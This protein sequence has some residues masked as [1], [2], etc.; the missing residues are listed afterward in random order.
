M[1]N[2]TDAQITYQVTED[3]YIN[4]QRL[5]R[6]RSSRWAHFGRWIMVLIGLAFAGLSLFTKLW[7]GVVV[8]LVYATMPWWMHRLISE[9]L[10]RRQY[11]KYPAIHQPQTLGVNDNGVVCSSIAGESRLTWN[12]ITRW[13]QDD[14]YLLLYVQPRLYFIIPKRADNAGTVIGRLQQLL[15]QHLGPAR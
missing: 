11:R 9:P 10:A 5:H 7:W 2:M 14:N 3:D 6:Q 1:S 4:A 12:L 13:T 15:A 8:G